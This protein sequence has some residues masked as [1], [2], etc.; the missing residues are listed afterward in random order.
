LIVV[1]YGSEHLRECCLNAEAGEQEF[2]PT[3]SSAIRSLIADSEALG[4]AGELLEFYGEAV[5]IQSDDSLLV[6]IAA[7]CSV[8]FVAV[9]DRVALDGDGRITWASVQRLK[10]VAI[11]RC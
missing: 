4:T 10:L 2:G 7:H 3:Y 11:V 6:E 8:R 9:G 1:T 5:Q